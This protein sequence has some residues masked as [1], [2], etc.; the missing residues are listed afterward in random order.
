MDRKTLFAM[1]AG[2]L[3]RLGVA[4][5]VAARPETRGPEAVYLAA[6]AIRLRIDAALAASRQPPA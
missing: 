2:H 3:R 1:I 6:R 5:P 4:S